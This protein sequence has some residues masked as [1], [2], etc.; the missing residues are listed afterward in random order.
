MKKILYVEDN[1][2]TAEAVKIILT[3]AGFDVTTKPTG[4]EGLTE[5]KKHNFDCIL[6]DIMLPDMSGWDIFE[7][8]KKSKIKAKYAFLSAIPVSVERKNDLMKS[9]V[10]EYITKPFTKTDL[11]NRVNKMLA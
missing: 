8:L 7:H 11:I 9:G 2:D 3:K 1:Q 5:A 4:Q 10:S 6:L